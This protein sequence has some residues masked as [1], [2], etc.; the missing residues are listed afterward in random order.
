MEFEVD[1]EL[2]WTALTSENQPTD[3]VKKDSSATA[4]TLSQTPGK[5]IPSGTD[6][7]LDHSSVHSTNQ[8]S[9][10]RYGPII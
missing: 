9:G 1:S 5:S 10:P 7:S 2:D 4:F 6:H 3:N 8:K